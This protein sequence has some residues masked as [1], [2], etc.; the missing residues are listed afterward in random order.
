MRGY[1]N[2]VNNL[3]LNKTFS[4]ISTNIISKHQ[5]VVERLIIS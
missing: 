4:Y 5:P 2:K 1:G 3:K